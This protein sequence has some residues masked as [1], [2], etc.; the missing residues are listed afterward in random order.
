MPDRNLELEVLRRN[1]HEDYLHVFADPDSNRSMAQ[2][3]RA[4]LTANHWDEGRWGEF[5]LL[6]RFE[7][8]RTVRKRVRA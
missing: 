1:R 6:V 5:E 8:E 2:Q 4:W 7:G 3:L